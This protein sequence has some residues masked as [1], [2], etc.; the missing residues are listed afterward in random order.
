MASPDEL[1]KLPIRYPVAIK[2]AIKEHFIY[3]TKVKAWRANN[4]EELMAL[5]ERAAAQVG[6]GEVMIQDFIPGDGRDQFA[7][8]ALFK[9]GKALGSVTVKRNRQHPAEFGKATTYAET[10]DMP[11]VKLLSES[12]LRSI[13]YYGLVELEYKRDS[14]DGLMK[15]IDVNPRTWGYHSIGSAAGVDFPYM[16]FSDQIGTTFDRQHGKVGIR[17][18]R[19]VTDLPTAFLGIVNGRLRI[20]DYLRSLCKV[21][22]EAVFCWDDPMPGLAELGMLPYLYLKRGF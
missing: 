15:L 19:I 10:V 21:D 11:E 14:R 22:T 5:F 18:I 2:P 12:F 1:S 7:Y 8:C 20:R 16:L 13:N 4:E 17:W 9:N 3:A 6:H